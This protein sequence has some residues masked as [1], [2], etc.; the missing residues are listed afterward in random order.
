MEDGLAMCGGRGGV[1]AI[2][3]YHTVVISRMDDSILGLRSYSAD[4]FVRTR[5]RVFGDS[6]S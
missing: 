3:V 5:V 6:K 2:D 4:D 1:M